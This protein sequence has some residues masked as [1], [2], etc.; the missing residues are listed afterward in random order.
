MLPRTMTTFRAPFETG[1]TTDPRLFD[2]VRRS[3]T[4]F[5]QGRRRIHR[6]W[7]QVYPVALTLTIFAVLIAA[8]M[9]LRFAIWVPLHRFVP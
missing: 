5:G 4:G 3:E 6:L 1:T 7:R 8:S 9:A 2:G